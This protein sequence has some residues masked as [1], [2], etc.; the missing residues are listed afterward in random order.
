MGPCAEAALLSV[1]SPRLGPIRPV[2]RI[3]PGVVMLLCPGDLV[4]SATKW[5][6]RC[7]SGLEPASVSERGKA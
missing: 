7:R 4:C 6:D 3:T 5:D 1:D 2:I